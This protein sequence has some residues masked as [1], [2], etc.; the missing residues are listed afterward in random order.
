MKKNCDDI[1][2]LPSLQ[3]ESIRDFDI[4][5]DD[6]IYTLINNDVYY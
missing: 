3:G 2:C 1:Y 5:I 4:I 6:S